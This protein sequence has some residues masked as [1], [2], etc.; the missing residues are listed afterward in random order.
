MVSWTVVVR[1]R[2]CM[3]CLL[4]NLIS[5]ARGMAGGSCCTSPESQSRPF[6]S[7]PKPPAASKPEL[8][9]FVCSTTV[10]LETS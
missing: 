6:R 10:V 3:V 2:V 5:K 7:L 8:D 9:H 1:H 4:L